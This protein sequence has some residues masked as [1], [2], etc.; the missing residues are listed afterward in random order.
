MKL[1][2]QEVCQAPELPVLH[3]AHVSLQMA[4]LALQAQHPCLDCMGEAF[5]GRPPPEQLLFA[6]LI[7]TRAQELEDMLCW[8][9][10]VLR[11]DN[12]SAYQQELPF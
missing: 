7:V 1:R 4:T 9:F 12:D 2:Y 5:P 11:R 3:A 8:Y 6:R 10:Q